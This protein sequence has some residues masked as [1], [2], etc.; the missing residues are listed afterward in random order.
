M[1]LRRAAPSNETKTSPT[2]PASAAS[3]AV[4]GQ[5]LPFRAAPA[6]RRVSA[7]PNA[8]TIV[9]LP[10]F[11][12]AA[13]DYC[14]ISPPPSE[15]ESKDEKEGLS[16]FSSLL[17][18]L[19]ASSEENNSS[20]DSDGDDSALAVATPPPPPPPPPSTLASA[21]EARGFAVAV[22]PVKRSDW[23]RVARCAVDPAYWRGEAEPETVREI[24][25]FLGREGGRRGEKDENGEK[26]EKKETKN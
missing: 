12:N 3:A 18:S 23:L 2:A 1:L 9:I 20:D 6:A 14:E 10:G 7:P 15:A 4:V 8:P 17:S 16:P 13:E 21:L 19:F 11:G 24:Y 26:K 5:I 25:S 22:V